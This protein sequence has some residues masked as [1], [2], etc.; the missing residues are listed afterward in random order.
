MS[1]EALARLVVDLPEHVEIVLGIDR[2]VLG[3]Q[4]AHVAERR[5]DLVAGAK[6]FVDRFRLGRQ[7][8][9]NDIHENPIS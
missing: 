1:F 9:D 6:I 5:Q 3:R 2:S 4:V 8:D 7:F